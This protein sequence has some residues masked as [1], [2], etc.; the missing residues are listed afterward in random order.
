MGT[1]YEETEL[2]PDDRTPA[3]VRLIQN[4]LRAAEKADPGCTSS[5]R[6]PSKK[7]QDAVAATVWGKSGKKGR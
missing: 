1:R 4:A 3:A 7:A 2:S 5:Y 6:E